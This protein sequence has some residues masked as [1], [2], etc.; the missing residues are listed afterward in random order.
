MT[1]SSSSPF[2][3]Q[4]VILLAS[5]A[6]ISFAAA[7]VVAIF[8]EDISAP[9]STGA[10][11]YSRSAIG[12]RGLVELLE[13]LDVP[14]LVSEH[15]SAGKARQGAA[16]IAAEPIV[17]NS[18]GKRARALRQ[19]M[20]ESSIM[21]LIM[22]KWYGL[23]S[24]TRPG[25]I[26][27]IQLLL[28]GEITPIFGAV[29]LSAELVR[30]T[31]PGPISGPQSAAQSLL[32][33]I[34]SSAEGTLFAV[35][36]LRAPQLIRSDSLAPVISTADGILL[37]VTTIDGQKAGR[38]DQDGRELW[39]LSDP[40]VL[41][42]HGLGKGQNAVLTAQLIQILRDRGSGTVVFD[43]TMH[44]FRKEPSLWRSLFE[45]PLAL[46]TIQAFLAVVLLLWASTGRFG[47]PLTP[48]PAIEPGKAF[49]IES[50]AMLLRF[51]HHADH[52]L[53][54]YFQTALRQVAHALHAPQHLG[55]QTRMAW[56]ERVAR[57][58]GI[59]ENLADLQREVGAVRRGRRADEARAVEVAHRIYRWREA[60]TRDS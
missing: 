26:D 43:E 1:E 22:P 24:A 16:L 49:L 52:A 29:G 60:M 46:V 53:E 18:D 3:R 33:Q 17:L 45:F 19:M 42:N 7:V 59:D 12:H 2:R 48:A 38:P 37:G 30:P 40:D 8:S 9:S 31:S 54:R 25:W 4:T 14:V 35:P 6:A 55:G 50:T 27:A 44:G 13:R 51:G 34:D 11:T 10:N 28:P 47:K 58:R 20:A 15:N 32:W 21:L 5:I 41:S 39:V 56:L 57:V 36:T 23:P